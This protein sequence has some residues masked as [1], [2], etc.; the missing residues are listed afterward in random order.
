MAL[1]DPYLHA[2]FRLG[3]LCLLFMPGSCAARLA[4]GSKAAADKAKWMHVADYNP[5]QAFADT[6]RAARVEVTMPRFVVPDTG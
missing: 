4:S 6:A 3:E 5:C 1:R 2:R